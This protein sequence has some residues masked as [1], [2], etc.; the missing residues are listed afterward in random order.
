MRFDKEKCWAKYWVSI[1]RK[2]QRAFVEIN[3]LTEK[4]KHS[5]KRGSWKGKESVWRANK[6]DGK[7]KETRWR[8][9][10]SHKLKVKGLESCNS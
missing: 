8:T 9:I 6:I 5:S 7:W 10:P 4:E 2:R 3:H 1:I